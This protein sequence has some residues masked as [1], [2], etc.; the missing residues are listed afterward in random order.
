MHLL[1]S[2]FGE[3]RRL[4]PMPPERRSRWKKEID[5]LLAVTDHIVVLVPTKQLHTNGII[6]EVTIFI[7]RSAN[8]LK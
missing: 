6:M 7:N 5:W 2:V 4:E 8:Y 1:A 3:Q